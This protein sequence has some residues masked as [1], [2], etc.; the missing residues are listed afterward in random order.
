MRWIY[1]KWKLWH[2]R[3]QYLVLPSE[4]GT[5][6]LYTPFI[7]LKIRVSVKETRIRHVIQIKLEYA[8]VDMHNIIIKGKHILQGNVIFTFIFPPHRLA[9]NLQEHISNSITYS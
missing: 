1:E 9:T 6:L 2:H 5:D 8:V 7:H 4:K 3:A